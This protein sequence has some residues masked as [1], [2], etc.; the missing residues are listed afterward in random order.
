MNKPDTTPG[1]VEISVPESYHAGHIDDSVWEEVEKYI[2]QGFFTCNAIIQNQY[3]VFKSLNHYECRILE[4]MRPF[5]KSSL[6]QRNYFRNAFIAQSVF[7]INGNNVLPEREKY[8]TK[9][10]KTISRFSNREL[11]KVF[12]NLTALNEKMSHVY[13]LTEVYSFEQKS[14]FRWLQVNTFPLNAVQNTG[15]LGTDNLGMNHSQLLWTALNKLYDQRDNIEAHWNHAKFVGST[16]AGKGIRSVDDR[17]R[18]RAE[19]EKSEREELRMKVLKN[20]L[21]RTA[22]SGESKAEKIN[23][24]DGR[25][26]EVVSRHRADTAEELAKQLT[27]ALNGE[28]DSHDIAV[29]NHF[30]KASARHQEIEQERRA[31]IG[32]VQREKP[33]AMGSSLIDKNEA[34]DRIKRLREMM[35]QAAT[36]NVTPNIEGSNSDKQ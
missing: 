19:R 30:R 16:M 5:T 12:D 35:F 15:I 17:D 34:E 22:Y 36:L 33:I 26:A 23:L 9:L 2:F 24:P 18:A 10:M 8:L 13:P 7:M 29:A 32:S 6:E 4:F 14:R 1:R 11:D 28:K 3:F 21:N 31:L 27:N 20:Y 25:T